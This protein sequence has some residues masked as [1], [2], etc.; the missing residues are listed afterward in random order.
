[1]EFTVPD[2]SQF[3]TSVFDGLLVGPPQPLPKNWLNDADYPKRA[4]VTFERIV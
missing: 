1:M 3:N 2:A 4:Y